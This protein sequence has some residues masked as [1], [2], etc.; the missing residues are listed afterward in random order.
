[1]DSALGLPLSDR[2]FHFVTASVLV[3]LACSVAFTLVAAWLRLRNLR[4]SERWEQLE[5][6]WEPVVLAVINGELVASD[7]Y[8]RV[9]KKDVRYVADFLLRYASRLKGAERETVTLLAAPY[10][11]LVASELKARSPEK[12]AYALRTLGELSVARYSAEFLRALDDPSPLV[13]MNAFQ[14]LARH[15]DLA[16]AK[17]LL[18]ALERFE[19]WSMRYLAAMLANMGSESLGVLRA[20]YGDPQ[21]PARVRGVLATTLANLNDARAA[22]IAARILETESQVD[23][24]VASLKLIEKVGGRDQLPAVRTFTVSPNPA[25]RAQAVTTL[26]RLG[27]SEDVDQIRSAL[28]DESNWVAIH[29]AQGLQALGKTDM[30]ERLE[31][32]NHP[33]AIAAREVLWERER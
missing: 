29:A 12:R 25:I 21:R 18:R 6:V 5:A 13:A 31:A 10:L 30:L 11:T 26:A 15:Y 24:I 4:L 27:T 3:L 19:F 8:R 23:L 9:R 20:A 7:F 14:A 22:E 28:D 17:R 16:Y 2:S 1:M 32:T 33:R